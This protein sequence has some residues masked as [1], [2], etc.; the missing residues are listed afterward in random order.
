MSLELKI[1]ALTA[2][3]EKLINVMTSV[4][5]FQEATQPSPVKTVKA[6]VEKP[7]PQQIPDQ[8]PNPS[9]ES[10]AAASAPLTYDPVRAAVL[11]Y[12]IKHGKAETL[13][14]LAEFNVTSGSQLTPEQWPA[15]LAKFNKL[16][17]GV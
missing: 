14:Q 13:A 7:A 11:A 4:S 3:V 2:A 16:N 10:P 8:G 1:D 12:N 17:G 5:S 15:V 9:P 6:K